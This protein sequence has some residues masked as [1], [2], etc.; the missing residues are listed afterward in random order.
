LEPDKLRLK[1]HQ[2]PPKQPGNHPK[3]LVAAQDCS[4]CGT[5]LLALIASLGVIAAYHL[6]YPEFQ[7]LAVLGPV[8]GV[9]IMSL[10]YILSRSP[11][12]PVLSHIAMQVAAVLVGLQSA[13]QLPPHY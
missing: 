7:G 9:G 11:L 1:S 12:A 13:L 4:K 5:G 2:I 6:D 3:V 10:A 8:F